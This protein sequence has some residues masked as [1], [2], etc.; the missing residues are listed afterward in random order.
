LFGD[1]WAMGAAES[2]PSPGAFP[3]LELPW[4]KGE[5]WWLTGGPHGGWGD[6]SAWAALDFVPDDEERGCYVSRR[7]ATAVAPGVVL[8]GGPGALW[9]D[10]DGDGQQQTGP[11][12]LYLHLAARERAA[13]GTRVRTGDRLGHPSCEGGISDAAH[14]HLARILDG[15]WLAAAGEEPF[16]LG[17]WTAT[18]GSRAYDGGLRRDDGEERTACACRLP[19]H[20]DVGR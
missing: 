14:L 19:G 16:V 2:T 8:F 4:P 1:P 12:V 18:G 5:A 13:P 9:L 10:L 6:G 15:R 3:R 17:R 20:N 11:A 7:W